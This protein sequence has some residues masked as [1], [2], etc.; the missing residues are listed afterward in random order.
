M[1]QPNGAMASPFR[2]HSEDRNGTQ[3][4]RCTQKNDIEGVSLIHYVPGY[5]DCNSRN[6]NTKQKDCR[7]DT[8][9]GPNVTASVEQYKQ[10]K[11]THGMLMEEH[12]SFEGRKQGTSEM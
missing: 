3:G 5:V 7:Q 4:H 11:A 2:D 9:D 8:S 6:N 10:K 12:A 1:S